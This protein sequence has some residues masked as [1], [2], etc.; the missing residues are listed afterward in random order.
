MPN[1][2]TTEDLYRIIS[3]MDLTSLSTT[4][5]DEVV[6]R[7]CIKAENPL[8]EHHS[9]YCAAVCVWPN[10]AL[11]ASTALAKSPVAVA[12]VAAAFPHGQ[13]PFSIKQDEIRYAIDHGASEID[14]TIH[15]GDFH[16]GEF[17][18][19][20]DE[21]AALKQACGTAHLKVI[22]E[23]CELPDLQA[24]RTA[25]DLALAAGADFIK[26][27][28]GKGSSG[29]TLATTQV[30]LDAVTHFQQKTG[31]VCGVKAAGGIRT[32]AEALSYLR[33]AD[34]SL[35]RA[36]PQNFRLGASS[37]LD[38]LITTLKSC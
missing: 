3:M 38:D 30:M 18:K 25:S 5:T 2:Q 34:Q 9:L 23:V 7:L 37:L 19:I 33:I 22:L 14:V 10:F 29:A 24:V 8:P 17:A 16:S 27:S 21:L 13:A 31:K 32:T 20:H 11:T 4:D 1:M 26:T 36:T 35:G 6:Q 15:R 12:C 28:T